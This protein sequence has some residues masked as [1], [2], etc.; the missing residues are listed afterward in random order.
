MHEYQCRFEE[1]DN[2]HEKQC[3]LPFHLLSL[4]W[5]F[6]LHTRPKPPADPQQRRD[7]A[8]LVNDRVLWNQDAERTRYWRKSWRMNAC[9]VNTP[10][11]SLL[12]LS[13]AE[14]PPIPA[15]C[16][17]VGHKRSAPRPRSHS[18]GINSLLCMFTKDVVVY[19]AECSLSAWCYESYYLG[20]SSVFSFIYLFCFLSSLT[21]KSISNSSGTLFH[22]Y[23][24]SSFPWKGCY[25]LFYIKR[26]R[27]R[28]NIID[29]IK[30]TLLAA[31]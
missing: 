3:R 26:G 15:Q 17:H 6:S 24:H 31:S 28:A 9:R 16:C 22:F 10:S 30:T 12:S 20:Q 1:W 13:I 2:V 7:P 23:L 18:L 19:D 5:D 27:S 14:L 11:T 29:K 8:K 25:V 4:V 21:F